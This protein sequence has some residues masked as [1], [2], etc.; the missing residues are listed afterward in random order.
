MIRTMFTKAATRTDMD[1]P[2]T[3][4]PFTSRRPLGPCRDHHPPD[5]WATLPGRRYIGPAGGPVI[6]IYTMG[7]RQC[8]QAGST[9]GRGLP[10][11]LPRENANE[12]GRHEKGP[13]SA[14][15]DRR[16][17][18]PGASGSLRLADPFAGSRPL[19]HRRATHHHDHRVKPAGALPRHPTQ[20]GLQLDS[21][22]PAPCVRGFPNGRDREPGL[23]GACFWW[24]CISHL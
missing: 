10:G 19:G 20:R 12:P 24:A 21:Q 4:A 5:R 7:R 11:T 13:L 23:F 1:N 6:H 8:R 17:T 22:T 16:T 2:P 9:G 18:E 3:A 15:H 14:P